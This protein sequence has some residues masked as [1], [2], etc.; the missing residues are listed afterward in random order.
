MYPVYTRCM[1]V[2]NVIEALNSARIKY[3]LV[4]GYAVALHGAIRGTV[5]LDF[6]IALNKKQYT[7]FEKVMTELGLVS[8][9]PVTADEVFNFRTEYIDNRNMIAWAFQNPDNPLEMIDVIITHDASKM[10]TKTLVIDGMKLQIATIDE[11]IQMKK[12]SGRPQDVEDICALER[13]K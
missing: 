6:V 9:L 7:D 4:G 3:A 8:R 11:L 5:D 13:L 2:K 1:F 12:T 10:G